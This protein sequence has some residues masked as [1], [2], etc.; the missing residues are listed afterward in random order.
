MLIS[1]DEREADDIRGLLPGRLAAALVRHRSVAAASRLLERRAGPVCVL[2][3]ASATAGGIPEAVGQVRR[4]APHAAVVVV[5]GKGAAAAGA[6]PP[7]DAVH[8]YVDTARYDREAFARTLRTALRRK[9]QEQ[10]EALADANA[11][12]HRD[13][14]V[15]E[16]GLLPAPVLRGEEVTAAFRYRPGQADA[17]LGGDFFDVVQ[18][19]DSEVH[20]V[21]GDVSGHGPAAAALAVHLRVTW[22]TAVLCG[23][24]QLRRLRLLEDVLCR[25]RQDDDTYAT[26]VSLV[27]SPDSG[28]MRVVNAGH[29]GFL[30]RG[31]GRVRRVEPAAGMALGLFPGRADW[32]EAEAQLCP[33]DSVLLFT[34]GLFEGRAGVSARLGEDNLLRLAARHA[35]L[36]GEDFVDALVADVMAEAAPFG[37]LTDDVAVLHLG[38]NPRRSP[39]RP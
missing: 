38:W 35:G 32:T 25:E 5:T 13:K 14:A 12:L 16:R 17:L 33:G 19:E 8:G 23:Q 22:R 37:G 6:A 34:D 18:T 9:H 28:R 27:L 7:A 20:V 24:S 4:R 30:L 29:P 36:A 1:Q 3:G 15:L 26:V 21:L 11:V 39:P 31:A 2:V 10:T